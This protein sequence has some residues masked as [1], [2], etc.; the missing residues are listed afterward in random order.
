MYRKKLTVAGALIAAAVSLAAAA[1]LGPG[2]EDAYTQSDITKANPNITVSSTEP[3]LAT[4]DIGDTKETVILTVSGEVLSVGD[5][6]PWTD[7]ADNPLGFVPVTIEIDEKGK[8]D[9]VG[10]YLTKG[11]KF[12]VYLGGIW[13]GGL[14]F[15]MDLEPQF[16]IGETVILHVGKDTNG[17]QFEDGGIYF[18]EL[19]KYG[20]YKVI[21]DKAYN[22][23]Y[24]QGRSLEDAL[25]EAR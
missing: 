8:D 20:K 6:I 17:P 7:E 14:Y 21:G 12:T 24:P 19:G 23:K 16:E 1:S 13:E 4:T 22:E 18:V 11:D 15:M 9:T 5:P 3:F 10:L 2:G 25:D